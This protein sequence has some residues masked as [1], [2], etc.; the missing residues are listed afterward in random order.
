[1]VAGAGNVY[2]SEVLFL[3][4]VNPFTPVEALTDA[5]VA[6]VVQTARSLLAANVGNAATGAI[7]TYVGM[8]RTTRRADPA[9][10]L[11]VYG[12]AGLPCRECGTLITRRAQGPDARL[13]Y[14]C[15]RCQP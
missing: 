2:K 3:S 8:R 12:R 5:K 15:P 13:T 9:E 10:R 14:W 6:E 4:R 11:W 1:V 7:V